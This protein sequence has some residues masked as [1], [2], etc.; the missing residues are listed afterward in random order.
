MPELDGFEATRLIRERECLGGGHIPVVAMTAHAMKGD[1]EKCL[2]AGMDGYVAKPLR[3]A[4]L[5][6]AVE[7]VVGSSPTEPLF[8]K[9]EA[10]RRVDGDPMLLR[11]MIELF[12]KEGPAVLADV[13]RAARAPD[14]VSLQIAAHTLKGMVGTFG[15]GALFT[16]A[17]ELESMA[18]R[19]DLTGASECCRDL[20]AGVPRLRTALEQ[21]AASLSVAAS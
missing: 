11:E 13:V 19:G 7:E 21:L 6:R 4:E 16:A 18:R 10:M 8:D 17:Q 12:A 9:A 3:P 5:Y 2:A 20:E 14:A 15:A 1:R